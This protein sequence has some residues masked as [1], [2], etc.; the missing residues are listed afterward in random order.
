MSASGATPRS[1]PPPAADV[2][3]A[4][5]VLSSGLQCG[6]SGVGVDLDVTTRAPTPITRVWSADAS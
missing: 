3:P 4:L 6:R 1:T 2:A 5:P